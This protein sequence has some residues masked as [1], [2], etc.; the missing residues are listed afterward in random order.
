MAEP[1]QAQIEKLP[2]WAQEHIAD[3]KRNLAASEGV[4]SRLIDEQ[5]PSPFYVDEWHSTPRFRRY[6]QAVNRTVSVEH[7][8]VHLDVFLAD[9]HDGQR[10]YGIELKWCAVGKRLSDGVA[11]LPR[12]YST[13]QLVT[14]ENI[15]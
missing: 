12:G 5:K 14:P 2:K 1:T 4:K 8:G 11:L 7:A 13:V 3:L 6:V 10:A 9:E 15:S